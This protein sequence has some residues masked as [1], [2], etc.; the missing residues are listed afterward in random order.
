MHGTKYLELM[1]WKNCFFFCGWLDSKDMF[2]IV[3]IM[4][5][6]NFRTWRICKYSCMYVFVGFLGNVFWGAEREQEKVFDVLF[7]KDVI[8][9]LLPSMTSI[10]NYRSRIKPCYKYRIKAAWSYFFKYGVHR[11]AFIQNGRMSGIF[12]VSQG[13]QYIDQEVKSVC[14]SYAGSSRPLDSSSAEVT[15]AFPVL[16]MY[17]TQPLA[18]AFLW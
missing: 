12:S 15:A 10:K 7:W 18:G 5:C 11:T 2:H 17:W 14:C 9:F 4:N 13:R 8:N 1:R 3:S 16:R 6:L